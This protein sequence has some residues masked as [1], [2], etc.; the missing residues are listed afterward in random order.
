MFA[1]RGKALRA[2]RRVSKMRYKKL[3]IFFL[4]ISISS[5]CVF[6]ATGRAHAADII[7][8]GMMKTALFP[9]ATMLAVANTL[10]V[11]A[12]IWTVEIFSKVL[13]MSVTTDL[14]VVRVAWRIVRDFCN[15]LFIV[16]LI[17][18]SF[19][20]I[21]GT[22]PGILGS[23][24][25]GF[26]ARKL[27]VSFILAALLINFSLPLCQL[28]A[29]IS[30][31]VSGIFLAS[32]GNSAN[33]IGQIIKPAGTLGAKVYNQESLGQQGKEAVA[34]QAGWGTTIACQVASFAGLP[35]AVGI[36]VNVTGF[37]KKVCV[38]ITEAASTFTNYAISSS[39][40]QI[41]NMVVGMFFSTLLTIMVTISII[42]AVFFA[43]IRIP[44]IWILIVF[45]PLFVLLNILPQTQPTAKR[46]MTEFISWNTFLPIFLFVLTFGMYFLS[47][48]GIVEH[49]LGIDLK[50]GFVDSLSLA[51][52]Y[53]LYNIMA[54]LIFIFGTAGAIKASREFSGSAAGVFEKYAQRPMSALTGYRP[55]W[56][57]GAK[58]A[59]GEKKK[60]IQQKG[61]PGKLGL[62][63]GGKEAEERWKQR[64]LGKAPTS[65][66]KFQKGIADQRNSLEARLKTMPGRTEQQAFLEKLKP[67]GVGTAERQIAARQILKERFDALN[68][69]EL[70]NTYTLMGGGEN[71]EAV[72][73]ASGLSFKDMTS[74]ERQLWYSQ[75]KSADVM[76][77][78]A[79]V[80]RDQ[81]DFKKGDLATRASAL[82]TAA[83]LLGSVDKQQQFLKDAGK[84]D[85]VAS[86]NAIFHMGLMTD[87][88]GNKIDPNSPGAEDKLNEEILKMASNLDKDGVKELVESDL[89]I[90][91]VR[92][93]IAESFGD[94]PKFAQQAIRAHA[95]LKE[96]GKQSKLRDI[97]VEDV[98]DKKLASLKQE[99]S[100]I[101]ADRTDLE[102]YRRQLRE[103]QGKRVSPPDQTVIND[104]T[105]R[106]GEL[107]R[108]VADSTKRRD[109]IKDAIDI[110]TE[111]K[112][113]I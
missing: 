15:M 58:Q 107:E 103:E 41:I 31:S 50:E 32:I 51:P 66:E 43:F 78:I 94:D 9:V 12:L 33:R 73:F 64:F 60:E 46:W 22:A 6:G 68:N 42:S 111:R 82:A 28:G 21:L 80:M 87:E 91:Y 98:V 55:A 1:R 88:A 96:K 48:K 27:L 110:E 99:L 10:S 77:K 49:G 92:K 17:I 14:E 93:G 45:S 90:A 34:S 81:G 79:E 65:F 62:V 26:D 2:P 53:V 67:K 36:L 23:W 47:S 108:R 100:D 29:S 113:K 7:T 106:I 39:T 83:R 71:V 101:E 37:A 75:V 57:T 19:G 86:Q 109:K 30:Q 56:Y 18:M 13:Q 3:T 70:F 35:P 112:K 59:Y 61:L 74:T 52:E 69:E 89:D 5:V 95:T 40:G 76:K 25:A 38:P 24:F 102:D 16:V 97:F 72:K 105:Q 84:K 8:E 63:Y 11:K 54:M 4:L 44:I 85:M 104:L 20:T